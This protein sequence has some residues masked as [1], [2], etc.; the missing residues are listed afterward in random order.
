MYLAAEADVLMS[1]RALRRA[2]KSFSEK[3]CDADAEE[4]E[5]EE[6]EED[7]EEWIIGV[8]RLSCVGAVPIAITRGSEDEEDEDEEDTEDE[9]AAEALA[10]AEV[11]SR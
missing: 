9:E 7:E 8:T 2:C 11:A 3:G 5:E 1:A 4:E 10:L 6:E